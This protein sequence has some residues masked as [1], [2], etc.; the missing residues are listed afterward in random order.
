M[1]EEHKAKYKIELDT[2]PVPGP[3]KIV[4]GRI[5]IM[6]KLGD[7][8]A[9]VF[10]CPRDV[11][12]TMKK[13]CGG[14]I[15]SVNMASGYFACPHC[16]LAGDA[17]YVSE[18]ASFRASENTLANLMEE[19][20]LLVGGDAEIYLKRFKASS[21]IHRESSKDTTLRHT[22]REALGRAKKEEVERVLY[23]FERL[24]KDNLAGMDMK[25]RFL[26][27]LRA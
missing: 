4:I 6:E 20:F 5:A 7:D 23:T 15:H 27:F 25:K 3:T 21:K 2:R 19:Y 24:M 1:I 26:T 13:G 17:M 16:G 11:P 10:R 12:K 22:Q 8:D 18:A 14:L 9:P